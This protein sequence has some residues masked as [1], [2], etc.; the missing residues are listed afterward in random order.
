MISE[1]RFVNHYKVVYVVC[2]N[3]PHMQWMKNDFLPFL[4]EVGKTEEESKDESSDN[5]EDQTTK[6]TQKR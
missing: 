3:F 1:L 4:D 5:A 2:N 6:E